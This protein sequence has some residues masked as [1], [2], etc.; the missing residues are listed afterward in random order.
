MRY[1]TYIEFVT[2]DKVR[3]TTLFQ[4]REI[5]LR[6]MR[7][8]DLRCDLQ[9]LKLS[10][11]RTSVYF[12]VCYGKGTIDEKYYI[13][14]SVKTKKS[15]RYETEKLEVNGRLNVVVQGHSI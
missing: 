2:Y 15:G 5:D 3:I 1:R 12:S 9:T 8:N 4:Q 13:R 7:K 14:V 11:D 10:K 6:H